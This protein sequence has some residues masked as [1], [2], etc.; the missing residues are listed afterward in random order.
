MDIETTVKIIVDAEIDRLERKLWKPEC[1]E[2]KVEEQ[3]QH[4][5]FEVLQSI[6]TD[7][8]RTSEFEEWKTIVNK[9]AADLA[10]KCSANQ[11]P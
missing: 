11:K 1:V 5:L 7:V 3:Q 9:A 6:H 10:E 2:V 8:F 4:Q